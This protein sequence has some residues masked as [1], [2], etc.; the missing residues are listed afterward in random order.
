MSR[1]SYNRRFEK[2]PEGLSRQGSARL[3]RTPSH[4][5]RQLEPVAVPSRSPKRW[6]R[7]LL[8][9]LGIVLLLDILTS[10]L[11]ESFWFQEVNFLSVFLT[12]RFTQFGA[13]GLVFAI[14]LATLWGNL[15]IAQSRQKG[16]SDV[17]T[18]GGNAGGLR[19]RWL[20][21]ITLG[22]SLILSMSLYYYGQIAIDYWHPRLN[23][24]NDISQIPT[25]VQPE[26]FLDLGE[27]MLL[28]PWLLGL[29][30]LGAIALLIYPSVISW[31][32]SFFMSLGFALVLSENWIR[33]LLALHP[34]P[35]EQADPLLSINIGFYIFQLPL[36]EVVVFWLLGLL[37]LTLL[38]VSLM[39][40]LAHNSLSDGRFSGFS[41]SQ[42][43]HLYRLG[44]ALMITIACSNWLDRYELLY[45]AEGV[46]YGASFTDVFIRFP[47]ATFLAGI[48]LLIGILL[49]ARSYQAVTP[50]YATTFRRP[51]WA[52]LEWSG[53]RPLV[54]LLVGYLG[55]MAIAN[56]LIPFF[57]QRIVVQPNELELERPYLERTIA[58]TRDAFGL[59]DIETAV[60]DPATSL[61]LEDLQNN[62]L[63]INNVR[64]W[65]TGPLQE[66]NRQLQRIRPYYEF[67]GADIDRYLLPQDDDDS[68]RL[69]Q[70][71]IALRELDYNAVPEE[72]QT[73]VNKHLIYT[74]GYGF[75]LSPVNT[76]VEGG[77]PDYFVSGIEQNV[78]DPRIRDAIPIGDPRIYFGEL[79][80]TYVMT[81]TQV[82]ELDY[83]SGDENVYHTYNGRG[84]IP[85]ANYWKRLLY[86]KHL[87]DWRMLFSANF[88]SDTRILFRRNIVSRVRTIAPF[89]RYDNDPYPVV[90]NLGDWGAEH[91]PK[92]A[93]D[94]P[95]S[96]NHVFWVMDAFTT[97][98]RYPYSDPLENDF[99]Y[100]RNS[101]KVVIDAYNGSV[102]F[103][104]A[105]PDDPLIQAWSRI[106][107]DMFLPL[108]EMPPAL[109]QHIR[110]PQDY[111]NV[112]SVQL[113]TY[114]MTDP[115]VFYNREDQWRS[116][117]EIYGEQ[118]Q[119]LEPYYLIMKLP[120]AT[121]EE[122]ILF[123]PFAPS[124][125]TN[126]IAWLAARSDDEDYG[127]I[128]LYRFPKQE[129]V[130]GTEQIEARINQDPVI[131]QQ[132]SLWNRRGSQAI[133]GNLLIIPIEDSLLY[134]E[135]LYLQAEQ[136]QIPS[137][138]RVIVAYG[139]R[140]VMAE[141]LENAL[142]AI[143]DP[144]QATTEDNDAPIIRPLEDI[145]TDLDALQELPTEDTL[146]TEAAP[147]P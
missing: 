8:I 118:Q 83:P 44:G 106:F 36:L 66:A 48:A 142:A 112:Q 47:A 110:Y 129:Q 61:T 54:L 111:Y 41:P 22:F 90:V 62:A 72:A 91:S 116:P 46:T 102:W 5:E 55:G 97:S 85:I 123:S 43:Q 146:P 3:A 30:G 138:T 96:T 69:R 136:N 93:S 39:Y 86:A 53:V 92:Q 71:L 45:S 23:L 103:F 73:W 107:P 140:I 21:P 115:Q 4:R 16:P 28:Q 144:T 124:Q 132:I 77:L 58:Q 104:V 65:D 133:Q 14:S 117:Q 40:L 24:Y 25:R 128:L 137:L 141:T 131:S 64:L 56:Y 70:V 98:D 52:Y 57:F 113:M 59:D 134:V 135:P 105:N 6:F 121:D 109:L 37:S 60:F 100:I 79:T 2:Q 10:F 108:S 38:S 7:N 9:G 75:T 12:R 67:P 1:S 19:L 35:F 29:V 17:D 13:A 26:V 27:R 42:L 34:I 18:A 88:T 94:T 33:I 143:F 15:A 84:G 32:M 126:L 63:T 11:A 89:L 147:I 50:A 81:Q 74:H 20:L 78:S 139:N 31:V 99:N 114:H 101:V 125:R 127:K 76:A 51:R 95:S 49:I 130:F 87:G 120:I 68:L 82:P 80:N 119:A 122:F 145:S